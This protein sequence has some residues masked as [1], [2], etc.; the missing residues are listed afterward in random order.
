MQKERR[1]GTREAG[2]PAGI[3][4]AVR[5]VRHRLRQ[6]VEIPVDVR[7]VRRGRLC[8][9]VCA[10]P[11]GS[12]AAYHDH[13]VLRGPGGPD[14]PHPH[15][16]EAGEKGSEMAHPRV[17]VLIR[18]HRPDGVLHGGHRMDRVLFRAVSHGKQPESG[19]FR[20]DRGPGRQRD[21][22]GGDG[23]DGLRRFVL[24]PA[25][26]PGA[27]HQIHDAAAFAA[28]AGAG[29]SQLHPGRRGGGPAVLPGAGPV[30]DHRQR[31]GGRHEPGILYPVGGHGGHGHFRQ[32][33]RQGEVPDG[34]VGEHHPAGYLCGHRGGADHVP[35]LL[36]LWGGGQRRP[37]PAV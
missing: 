33:H 37:Q 14:Q 21:L 17:C 20:N 9:A 13:G 2:V 35:G 12:G 36:Y 3:H 31:G 5:R 7:P 30:Q 26:R 6:C 8:A 1:Y 4:P 32:L 23:G 18:Q 34:G 16:S 19:V 29:R 15:V 25:E 27:G 24:R 10:V 22:S 11:G 28:D